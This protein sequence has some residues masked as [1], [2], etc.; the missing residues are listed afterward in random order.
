MLEGMAEYYSKNS[1]R[2]VMKDVIENVEKCLFSEG[3]PPLSYKYKI[4]KEK[5]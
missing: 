3:K 5:Q 1:S 4:K 2:E